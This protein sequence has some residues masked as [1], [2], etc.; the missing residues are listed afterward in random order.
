MANCGGTASFAGIPRALL[1]EALH[2]KLCL[3][4]A[5]KVLNLIGQKGPMGDDGEC[6]ADAKVIFWS[7]PFGE[8]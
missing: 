5:D 8:D 1:G 3:N 4:L 2:T 6:H 7:L